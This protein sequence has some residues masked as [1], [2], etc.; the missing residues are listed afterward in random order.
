MNDEQDFPTHDRSTTTARFFSK[1][2]RYR[3]LFLRRWWVLVL[4]VGL[5]LA[6]TVAFIKF[7]AQEYVSRGQMIV[8]IKINT[9]QGSLYTEELGNFLGTQAALMQGSEVQ[10]RA[11]ASV[12]SQDS[13]LVP[14]PVTLN[15][16]VLPKTTIFL[17]SATGG[18]SNYTKAFLQACMDEYISFK[19]E[20]AER[21]STKS[22]AGLT[23]QI[24][25]LE[26]E[27]QKSD[28]QILAFLG[29]N[30]AALLQ[31][32]SSVGNYLAILYQEQATAQS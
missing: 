22:I 29:T 7:A 25:R 17:L 31:E 27:M 18:N 32:A 24:L 5:A 13:K 2:H 30:D 6:G 4:A 23:D 15:V 19:K 28:D 1:L 8:S 20:M 26:P 11:R 3:N 14:C 10:Q 21:T 16:S 9:Q 12:A